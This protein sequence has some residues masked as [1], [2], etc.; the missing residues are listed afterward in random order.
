MIDAFAAE[1][2]KARS[3]RSTPTI[4]AVL[5]A[6][7]LMSAALT[8]YAVQAGHTKHVT[9]SYPPE[10]AGVFAQLA[11]AVF[12]VLAISGEY[13]SGMIRTSLTAVP[14]REVFLAAKAAMVAAFAFDAGL[15]V[16]LASYLV[17]TVAVGDS[18]IY[19]TSVAEA[20]HPVATLAALALSL[21]MF[22]LLG[23]ALGAILRSTAGAIGSLA[24]VWWL[25]PILA[26]NLSSPWNSRVASLL[27][28]ELVDELA[29]V[30]MRSS[31]AGP[32]LL[33]P[34]G[35]LAAIVCWMFLP[36]A[37]AWAV[38]SRRDAM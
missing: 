22:A 26:G 31:M 33:S 15:V 27:P 17:C 35:A 28:A 11:L 12:G 24:A 19:G 8:V 1:W 4:L 16:L 23:L 10:I 37:V 7:I 36:L 18:T 14:R 21:V 38:M 30:H 9:L 2:L 34:P 3:V 5:A 6:I 29:G 32:E 13:A 25:L 20:R